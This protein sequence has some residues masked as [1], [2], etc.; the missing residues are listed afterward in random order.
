MTPP[1]SLDGRLQGA[2]GSPWGRGLT[3]AQAP[4]RL[5]VDLWSTVDPTSALFGLDGGRSRRE[6][7]WSLGLETAHAGAMAAARLPVGGLDALEL[8]NKL[9]AFAYFQDAHPESPTGTYDRLWWL[10][11]RGFHQRLA[12]STAAASGLGLALA[13]DH[14]RDLDPAAG[15]ASRT[16]V[17]GAVA[18][19][20]HQVEGQVPG[21]YRLAA[22]ENLGL[23][24]GNLRPH[25]L[26][27][28]AAAARE[29]GFAGA[30]WHGS[31]RGL[32]FAPSDLGPKWGRWSAI[33]R[34]I[35]RTPESGLGHAVAGLAWALTLVNV[36]HPQVPAARLKGLPDDPRQ[37]PM[38]WVLQGM[39]AALMLWQSADDDRAMVDRFLD[40]PW[41]GPWLD[42]IRD[43]WQARF[44]ALRASD[45]WADL[46]EYQPV[47]QEP[48]TGGV[49]VRAQS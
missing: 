12:D 39:A 41:P 25:L 1:F 15:E 45:R 20:S 48:M 23:V 42:V 44:D 33:R 29:Q 13:A 26:P 36:R 35:A 6:N 17:E 30:V 40:Y 8:A 3:I 2:S 19:F 37:R 21:K 34:L 31:G 7:S 32:Y 28:V 9:R 46:F 49:H 5:A 27:T 14:F 11:G 22:L 4:W 24:V 47:P 43:H 16:A 18:G 10:E 38:P